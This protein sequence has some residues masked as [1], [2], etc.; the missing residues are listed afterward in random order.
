MKN[1][2][3]CHCYEELESGIQTKKAFILPYK[4][5]Y[6]T[7]NIDGQDGLWLY[8][9]YRLAKNPCTTYLNSDQ[10]LWWPAEGQN[11]TKIYKDYDNNVVEKALNCKIWDYEWCYKEVEKYAYNLLIWNET[12]EYFS[13]RMDVLKRMVDNKE[14]DD[15]NEEWYYID[16]SL[17]H[18]DCVTN[19]ENK[20][21]KREN[22]SEYC[23]YELM[24][25]C[26][27]KDFCDKLKPEL[28]KRFWGNNVLYRNMPYLWWGLNIVSDKTY[29][30]NEDYWIQVLLWKAFSW[31]FIQNNGD[32]NK[33]SILFTTYNPNNSS[34]DLV[35]KRWQEYAFLKYVFNKD[36]IIDENKYGKYTYLWKN[37]KYQFIKKTYDEN[38]N[39]DD[40]KI[41]DVK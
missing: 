14:F 12:N 28:D 29:Y 15:S 34:Y 13:L 3:I 2:F 22:I 31:W 1:K 30:Y 36:E 41:F 25:L 24:W 26:P 33:Y 39:Y 35:W 16:W 10:I 7:Y 9:Y 21:N 27:G 5:W 19:Y 11:M 8:V 18:F 32:K 20:T 37:N 17:K 4:D 38:V 23:M 40:L 6:F